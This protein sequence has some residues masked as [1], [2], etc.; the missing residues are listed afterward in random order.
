MRINV[1]DT[2]AI[3]PVWDEGYICCRDFQG[4]IV[5][6]ICSLVAGVAE[7]SLVLSAVR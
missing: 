3:R 7:C 2:A 6:I 4:L 5:F 1:D